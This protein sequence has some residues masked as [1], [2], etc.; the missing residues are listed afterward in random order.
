MQPAAVMWNVLPHL[1]GKNPFV[2]QH[3]VCHSFTDLDAGGILPG[4][5]DIV[6]KAQHRYAAFGR[7]A[8]RV[9]KTPVAHVC[10]NRAISLVKSPQPRQ[11]FVPIVQWWRQVLEDSA[12][13]EI[14]E[15]Q[16]F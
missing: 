16:W 5:I 2:L 7:Y 1:V 12:P 11:S 15:A 6:T 13:T 14:L 10:G 3:N 4:K 9:K 8:H